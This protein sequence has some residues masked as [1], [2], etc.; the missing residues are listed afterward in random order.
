MSKFTERSNYNARN[1]RYDLLPFRFKRLG[2][3]EVLVS[4]YTYGFPMSM[5]RILMLGIYA[6]GLASTWKNYFIFFELKSIQ[7]KH[8]LLGLGALLTINMLLGFVFGYTGMIVN[9]VGVSTFAHYLF[10]GCGLVVA[11]GVFSWVTLKT[12]PWSLE[13]ILILGLMGVPVSLLDSQFSPQT[14][15]QTALA[16]ILFSWTSVVLTYLLFLGY[17]WLTKSPR[18]AE[19]ITGSTGVS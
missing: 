2:D 3:D 14:L 18:H 4:V 17:D 10:I 16:N 9:G 13:H 6:A 15:L 19:P 7:W 5:F 12:R 11:I 8:L 1:D